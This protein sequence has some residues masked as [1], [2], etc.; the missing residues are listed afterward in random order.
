MVD[1]PAVKL[2]YDIYH[3]QVMEGDIIRTINQYHA[4]LGHYHTAGNP[5]RHELDKTQEL[6]YEPIIRAI[7]TTGYQGYIG[8]EFIPTTNPEAGLRQAFEICTVNV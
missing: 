7:A 8:Q 6:Q 2:L 3:M 5:G 4:Y 1:S